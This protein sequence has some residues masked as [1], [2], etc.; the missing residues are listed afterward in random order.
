MARNIFKLLVM[1]VFLCPTSLWAEGTPVH[2]LGSVLPAWSVIPFAGM[3]LSIA[4]L[5][6]LT[7][8]FW[9]HHYAKITAGWS[10][11]L[12]VPFTHSYGPEAWK[13]LSHMIILD[14]IPFIILLAVL[15]TIGGGIYI[16]GSFHG[17]PKVNT[18]FLA[19][20]TVLASLIGTTGASMLL[21]RPLLRANH[22]RSY[23]THTV[24]FFIFL[25]ANIGGCLTPLGDPP[26][27]LGFLHG[28]PFFWTLKLWKEMACA[29]G[30]LLII[31]FLLDQFHWKKENSEVRGMVNTVAKPFHLDGLRNLLFLSGVL[32]AII[33]SGKVHL[34]EISFLGVHQSIENL[35][36]DGF[37]LMMLAG[38]WFTT[39]SKIH[40][41]NHFSWD[42]IREVA[43]LFAGIFITMIPA[44]AILKAG[45]GG[46]LAPF[47]RSVKS[48]AHFFW[49]AGLLSSFLD[50]APTYL[51]FLSTALGKLYP[52]ILEHTAILK[53]IQEN[54][55]F[56]QAIATGSV[57]MGANSYIGNAP[58][59]MVKSIAEKS[60]IRMPS[61]FGY[62]FCY[63]LPFLIPVFL[64]ATWLFFR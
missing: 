41:E 10:L 38:S 29:G 5:P 7:P 47:I 57:F 64:L 21:I 28:V 26:L 49:S 2:D 43:I 31:Y 37:L 23:K 19:I 25:V 48:P 54:H 62:I 30:S 51:T 15:F 45:E 55:S 13:A 42:P 17:S 6:L 40:E 53:L 35:L 33:L 4:L 20:G 3:L 9:H 32:L 46:A 39:E 14:Y 61:F 11:L 8:D 56:L 52:G 18:A 50:N 22:A 60:N 44:L 24:I 63:T 34:G 58:N 27:F 1:G 16:H 36:R 12:L 59:F